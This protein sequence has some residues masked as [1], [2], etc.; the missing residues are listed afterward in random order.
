VNSDVKHVIF[1]SRTL[2]IDVSRTLQIDVSRTLQIDDNLDEIMVNEEA[3]G[4]GGGWDDVATFNC[5]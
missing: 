3:G 1:I 5:P 2:Q 4:S